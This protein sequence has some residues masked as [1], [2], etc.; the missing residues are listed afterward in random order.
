MVDPSEQSVGNAITVLTE[1][2][3]RVRAARPE[4]IESLPAARDRILEDLGA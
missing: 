4:L 1:C 2:L 3:A